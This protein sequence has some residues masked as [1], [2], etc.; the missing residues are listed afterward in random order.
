MKKENLRSVIQ[1]DFNE[2]LLTGEYCVHHVFPGVSRRRKCE[3]YGF[4][5]ALRPAMHWEIHNE[6]NG[7]I[8]SMLKDACKKYWVEHIGTLE[9]FQLEFR[10]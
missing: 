5:V 4:L 2:L 6:P 10:Y 9:D 3:E 7:T 1:D 8:D